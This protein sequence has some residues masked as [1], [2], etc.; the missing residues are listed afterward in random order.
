M[1]KKKEK[2]LRAILLEYVVKREF[3]LI[4][5]FAHMVMELF[6]YLILEIVVLF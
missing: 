4:S 5:C 1:N 6:D 2:F 3:N